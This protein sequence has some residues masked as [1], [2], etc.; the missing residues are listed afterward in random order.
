MDWIA[1][2]D[3][4]LEQLT[5]PFVRNPILLLAFY[6]AVPYHVTMIARD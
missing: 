3:S 2:R 1:S 4:L 6:I 5:N